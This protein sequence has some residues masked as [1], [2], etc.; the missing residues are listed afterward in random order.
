MPAAEGPVVV[1]ATP[2]KGQS[3]LGWC[4]SSVM[5]QQPL[6]S[7][8]ATEGQRPPGRP[9]VR[10]TSF[11]IGDVFPAD[12]PAK[13]ALVQFLVAAQSLLAVGKLDLLLP[14][15]DAVLSDARRLLL[16]MTIGLLRETEEAVKAVEDQGWLKRLEQ[17]LKGQ[18]AQ[19]QEDLSK[20]IGRL[21]SELAIVNDESLLRRFLLR[22]RNKVSFH[23]DKKEIK[24]ALAAS[25]G[26]DASALVALATSIGEGKAPRAA[27]MIIPLANSVLFVIL[28]KIAGSAERLVE[29]GS[30]LAQIQ[31]D[32]FHVAHALYGIALRDAGI[33]LSTEVA[34]SAA[35][36]GER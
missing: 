26:Q 20:R 15:E 18:D 5:E 11:R 7:E 17:E 24:N 16:I 2:T 33:E 13:I 14:A 19:V 6:M 10:Y 36:G 22:A 35:T 23:W 21:R 27:Q 30:V 25:A 8:E 34:D 28:E 29:L 1:D 12:D 4:G 9:A 32:V 3:G 31:G